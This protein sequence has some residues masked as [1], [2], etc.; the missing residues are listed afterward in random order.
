MLTSRERQVLQL[1]A[2]GWSNGE[3]AAR[4]F[5][6]PRTAETHRTNLM[7]KLNLHKQTELVHFALR[8]GLIRQEI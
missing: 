6:R 3:I 8:R 2:E 1:A 7:G 4:L 5:I